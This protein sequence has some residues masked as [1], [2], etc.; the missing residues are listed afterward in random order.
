MLV[1]VA[2]TGKNCGIH[3]GIIMDLIMVLMLMAKVHCVSLKYNGIDVD[4]KVT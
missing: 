3:D 4:D 2:G 1:F